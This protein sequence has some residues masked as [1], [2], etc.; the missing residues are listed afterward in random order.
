MPRTNPIPPTPFCSRSTPTAP[1]HSTQDP[2]LPLALP[3]PTHHTP[4]H[5][6]PSPAATRP[7]GPARRRHARRVADSAA[8]LPGLHH[9]A[10]A[11]GPHAAGGGAR[12][13]GHD[14]ALPGLQVQEHHH[15]LS[16]WPSP[17]Q[18][19]QNGACSRGACKTGS[20]A[21]ARHPVW[22]SVQDGCMATF[23]AQCLRMAALWLHR[24]GAL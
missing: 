17:G 23:P 2:P 24:A 13:A 15:L 11:Q 9:A 10:A 18:Q 8:G 12:H 7:S 3:P 14:G 22:M 16:E 4:T 20:T 5:P 21:L 1:T 6:S 19:R